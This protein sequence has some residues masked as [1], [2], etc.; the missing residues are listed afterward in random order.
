MANKE[1][2]ASCFGKITVLWMLYEEETMNPCAYTK[3]QRE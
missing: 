3:Y 2:I 1:E